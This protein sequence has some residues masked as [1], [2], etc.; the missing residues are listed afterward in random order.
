MKKEKG[1]VGGRHTVQ[2][3]TQRHRKQKKLKGRK[4]HGIMT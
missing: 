1:I 3:K 4:C 2:S